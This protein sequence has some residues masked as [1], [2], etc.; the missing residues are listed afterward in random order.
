MAPIFSTAVRVLL[1]MAT[2]KQDIKDLIV[3]T[4]D[5][6]E[7][8]TGVDKM[9]KVRASIAKA[10]G[11]EDQIEAVWDTVAPFFNTLVADTKTARTAIEAQH[12]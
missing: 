5:L 2:H 8:A 6:F 12:N 4:E 3:A 11:V 1:F 9:N 10:L 7:S